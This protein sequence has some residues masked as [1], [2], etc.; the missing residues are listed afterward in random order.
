M[1]ARLAWGA[2]EI[3]V[4][5]YAERNRGDEAA[6]SSCGWEHSGGARHA[7]GASAHRLGAL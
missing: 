7:R 5:F 2:D 6:T 3:W 4:L 1:D